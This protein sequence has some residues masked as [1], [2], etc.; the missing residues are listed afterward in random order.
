VIALCVK[1]HATAVA[2]REIGRHGRKGAT[3]VSFQNGVSNVE[4]LRSKLPRFEIVPGMVPFNVARLGPASW[5]KG[6]SGDLAVGESDATRMLGAQLN[7]GP[8]RLTL[9]G[10]MTALAWGKL[11]MNLNNAVNALSRRTLLDE[12]G[13]R[14]YRRVVAASIVEALDLL[15]TA[16][17]EPAQV[18]PIPPKLLPHAIAAP[19]FIFKNLLLRVQ[20]IDAKARSSMADDLA[21]GRETEIDY[22]NGEIVKL[23]R[24][25]GRDA[26]V[27]RTLVDLVKQAEAGVDI[28]W[29]PEEL[30]KYVL[31]G[32]REVAPF[33]Y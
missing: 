28:A 5:H 7:R 30:R 15:G 29:S 33:G 6:T 4:A 22:L 14:D 11:L 27:N 1:S 10:D 23:A 8:A 26:P 18:G 3:V 12:L 19:N 13:E 21:A 24:S 31:Q 25:L 20:K 9:V 32:H 16:G 2:A 17:I